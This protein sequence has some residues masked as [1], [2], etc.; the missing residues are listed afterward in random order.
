MDKLLH[1]PILSFGI[2][3]KDKS[4][5]RLIKEHF[6]QKKYHALVPTYKNKF[7]KV[8]LGKCLISWQ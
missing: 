3:K 6:K 1:V 4:T 5:C 2:K 7:L 8:I